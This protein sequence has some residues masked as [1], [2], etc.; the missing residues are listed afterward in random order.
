M[1][2]QLYYYLNRLTIWCI[3]FF[4]YQTEFLP[5]FPTLCCIACFNTFS[6]RFCFPFSLNNLVCCHI[7]IFHAENCVLR[8]LMNIIELYTKYKAVEIL[9]TFSPVVANGALNHCSNVLQDLN[10]EGNKKFKRAHSSGS[11]FCK[12]VPVNS[13]RCVARQWVFKTCVNLQW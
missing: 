9:L 11:L 1:K 10:I 6:K 2:A 5:F 8:I 7:M 4:V 3:Q 13:K 12:G